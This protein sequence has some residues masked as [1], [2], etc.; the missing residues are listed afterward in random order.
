MHPF[1]PVLDR[2]RLMAVALT[3][4]GAL[5]FHAPGAFADGKDGGA[6]RAPRATVRIGGVSAVLVASDEQLHVFLDRIAD[7]APA[8]DAA[9]TVTRA[10]SRQPLVFTKVADGL[11]L[12]PYKRGGHQ[13]DVFK[14]ALES[15]D[16]TGEAQAILA[17]ETDAVAPPRGTGFAGLFAVASLS[18]LIGAAATVFAMHRWRRRT[19]PPV[20]LVKTT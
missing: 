20:P 18:A 15:A 11:F 3:L 10:G 6:G 12:A 14:L 5:A 13:Q 7:N 4:I 17:Y 2:F 19:K 16:G 8:G 1:R 9:I